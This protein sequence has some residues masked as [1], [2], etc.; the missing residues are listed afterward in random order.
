MQVTFGVTMLAL[1]HGTP[2]SFNLKEM[3]QHFLDHRMKCYS[4]NKV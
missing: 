2:Q 4:Q 1:V 3:I